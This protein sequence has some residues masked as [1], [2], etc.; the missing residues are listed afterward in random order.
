MREQSF[1]LIDDPWIR[2]MTKEKKE[3]MVSLKEL[4]ID[5][6]NFLAI[7]GET[8]LQDN[9]VLRFLIA[10]S[11]TCFYRYDGKG[12]EY[13][14]EDED[15]A[16]ERFKMVW[17]NKS[18]PERFIG[19]YLDKWHDRFYLLGGENPFYQV[20]EKY[21]RELQAKPDKKKPTGVSFLVSPYSDA[22]KMGWINAMSFNGEVLQ[23]GNTVSPFSNLGEEEKNR[24]SYDEA[25]RWLLYYM[26]YADCSSKIPGKWNA[27][28][29]F[30]AS[31]ANTHPIGQ[32]LFETIMLCSV[33]LDHN[34]L[35][36]PKVSPAWERDTGTKINE[37]PYGETF[38]D[39][40]P[41]IYTQQARKVILHD[42]NGNINGMFTAA[43]DRYGTKNAFIEPMFAFHMDSSDKSGNTKKPN[44]IPQ[45]AIGWKEYK[46]IFMDDNTN[47]ARWIDYLEENEILTYDISIPFAMNDIAYGSNQCGVDYT[48]NARIMLN[49]KFFRDSREIQ[50]ACKEIENINEISGILRR[51]GQ[52]VDLAYGAKRDSKGAHESKVASRLVEEFERSAGNLIEDYLAGRKNDIEELHKEEIRAAKKAADNVLDS[53]N[54]L[55]YIGH[56]DNSIGNAENGFRRDIYSIEKKLGLLKGGENL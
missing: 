14:L 29:T 25:A 6:Q 39:N 24:M 21:R 5:C 32:N 35:L 52:R 54:L 31:G 51:F 13:P 45:G 30:A 43:G 7:S 4:F 27:R 3:K 2:V 40:L 47:P 41:E 34:Y 9:A 20:P 48:V 55:G 19:T 26:N 28:M 50:N 17:N 42:I 37:S 49:D 8:A 56:G 36:Y 46:N 23:S 53:I 10:I 38:P 33:L 16:I 1:N 18:F 11:V 22:D 15:G 12:N 44:H